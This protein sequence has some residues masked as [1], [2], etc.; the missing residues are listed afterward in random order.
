MRLL[1]GLGGKALSCGC[2]VGVYETYDGQVVASIDAPA[3][4]CTLHRLHQVL[5]EPPAPAPETDAD[6]PSDEHHPAAR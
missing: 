3:S 6:G 2:M 5:A 4:G 1:R